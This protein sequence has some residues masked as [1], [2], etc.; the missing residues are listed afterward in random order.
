[1]RV[2][3]HVCVHMHTCACV[4]AHA[5]DRAARV[6]PCDVH[7]HTH[8]HAHVHTARACTRVCTHTQHT[9]AHACVHVHVSCSCQRQRCVHAR[10]HLMA[11]V[12]RARTRACAHR[13]QPRHAAATHTFSFRLNAS[14]NEL[15]RSLGG[16]SL[17]V[18][19]RFEDWFGLLSVARG[20][21]T[22]PRLRARTLCAA[23]SSSVF[24]S[25]F[26][27]SMQRCTFCLFFNLCFLAASE[28]P[29]NSPDMTSKAACFA[30]SAQAL[31]FRFSLYSTFL[32]VRN[33][34]LDPSLN[35]EQGVHEWFSS[36]VHFC[37]SIFKNLKKIGVK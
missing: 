4:R 7:A 18:F 24:P 35:R 6:D 27:R 30:T 21:L 9:C 32:W 13:T 26:H 36:K 10:E 12:Q 20:V 1:M 34:L 22:S 28:A 37:R 14:V 16:V 33:D 3:T 19:S 25:A 2:C 5:A 31:Y 17:R 29:E 15:Q 8:V 23:F 11:C